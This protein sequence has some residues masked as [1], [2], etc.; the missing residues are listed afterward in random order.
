MKKLIPLA[1]IVILVLVTAPAV[2]ADAARGQGVYMNFCAPCHASGIA[3]APRVGDKPAWS[4]RSAKDADVVISNA[5]NGYQ[6]KSG[7]MPAKGGN[8]AL[9]DEEVSAAVMYML[10]QSR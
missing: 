2:F 1:M 8:S 7:F 5:I 6:G 9:T 10:E 4:E 3:S